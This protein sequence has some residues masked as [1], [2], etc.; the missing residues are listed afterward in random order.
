M[1]AI[2]YLRR[3]NW[4]SVCIPKKNSICCHFV[5][6]FIERMKILRRNPPG[7]RVKNGQKTLCQDYFKYVPQKSISNVQHQM[8]QT[9][10]EAYISET[11]EST[12]EMSQEFQEEVIFGA[13][14]DNYFY[15]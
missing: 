4:L 2:N 12:D 8:S 13:I 6:N 10:F 5:L 15:L 1:K 9:S 14:S 7:V 3:K 11:R